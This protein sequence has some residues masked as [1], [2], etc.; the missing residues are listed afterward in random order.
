MKILLIS[1]TL[2]ATASLFLFCKHQ[3]KFTAENLPPQQLRW[4]T[5]GGFVGKETVYTL[6]NNGQV[7][8][9][10][11]NS[12]LAET[13]KT[14]KKTATAIYKTAAALE[15][16]KLEFDH[17]GNI[18]SFLEWQDGDMVHRV[19]WGDPAFPVDAGIKTLYDQLNGLLT[20]Q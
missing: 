5:G 3:P 2:I 18:Y 15:L 8:K 16:S 6:L 17:A 13:A 12:P 1:L 11:L 9:R 20:Q 19:S 10:G 4:G 7:F 14:K